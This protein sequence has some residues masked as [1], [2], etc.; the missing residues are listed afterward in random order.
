MVGEWEIMILG[1]FNND[2]RLHRE[3]VWWYKFSPG[4]PIVI[5]K[6]IAF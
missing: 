3:T 6:K 1:I 2:Y 5:L 4:K